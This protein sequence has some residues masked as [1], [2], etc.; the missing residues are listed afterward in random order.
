MTR[1]ALPI[2]STLAAA[3]AGAAALAFFYAKSE[4]RPIA[5]PSERPF[6][7]DLVR[8]VVASGALVPRREVTVKPHASGVIEKLYVE[9]GQR[10]K[11]GALLA[12]IR[13]M[14]NVMLID[15]AD[16][17]VS[18]ARINLETASREA[19]RFGLLYDQRLVSETEF[20]QRKLE[21]ELRRAEL[22]A[23]ESNRALLVRGSSPGRAVGAANVVTATID[24]TV[25][26][27][28]VKEGGP[29]IEA[30]NFNEGTTI[31]SLA[32]M[33][34]MIFKGRIEESEVGQLREGMAVSIA[35]GALGSERFDAT[36]ERI[37]PKGSEKDGV[38]EFEIQAALK[39]KPGL[40]VRANYSATADVILARRERVLAVEERWVVF[41]H[42]QSFVEIETAPQRFERRAVELGLSDGVNVE[43]SSGIDAETRLKRPADEPAASEN[44]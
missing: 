44:R 6:V 27:L 31:A 22:D 39:A 1:R 17:R 35:V 37:A 41:D 5:Y 14:S 15:A 24:G 42:G 10:V 19:E 34:D 11:Q 13:V 3:L 18:A 25:L 28:P 21:S 9:P 33:S 20:N 4:A 30:N 32:D 29:V 7:T 26:D 43:V 2:G 38:V 40:S 36:L 12:K 23:P 16:A 8:K